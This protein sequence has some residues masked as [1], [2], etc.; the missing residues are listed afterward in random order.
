MK[1]VAQL[2]L[3]VKVTKDNSHVSDDPSLLG[4]IHLPKVLSTHFSEP[5]QPLPIQNYV[6]EA[7]ASINDFF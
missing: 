3:D 2:T 6:I 4:D 7:E 1:E 5:V